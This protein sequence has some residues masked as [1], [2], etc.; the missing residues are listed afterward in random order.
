[1]GLVAWTL[2]VRDCEVKVKEGTQMH[3]G[4]KF[5]K[6]FNTAKAEIEVNKQAE[7]RSQVIRYNEVQIHKARG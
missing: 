2:T 3:S 1:M 4:V 5:K 6:R 7:V